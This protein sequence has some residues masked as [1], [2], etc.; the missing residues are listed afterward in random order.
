MTLAQPS[1]ARQIAARVEADTADVR[2][3]RILAVCDRP[4]R[5]GRPTSDGNTLIAV[6]V[7]RR[8]APQCDLTLAWFQETD[9]APDP[10]LV[11]RCRALVPLR[12]SSRVRGLAGLLTGT[13]M[14]ALRRS[15]RR[16]VR[17][18]RE[19]ERDADVVYLHGPATLML[20]GRLE[21]PC[22]VNEIDPLSLVFD[23]QFRR[24]TALGRIDA[25]VRR[26]SAA[27]AERHAR[28][29]AEAY[30]L[31]NPDDARELAAQLRASVTALPNGV[32]P[33]ECRCERSRGARRLC[34]VGALDYGPNI[35]SARFLVQE[36]LPLVRQHFRDIEIVIAG[37]NAVE[38]VRV[39]AHHRGVHILSDV[40]DVMDVYAD[41][42]IAVFPGG[43]GRGTRNSVL[44]AL[45]AGIPSIASAVSAR[46]VQPGEH[47]RIAD[48][49]SEV[50]DAILT[51]VSNPEVYRRAERA[52]GTYGAALPSW[53]W[54]AG[55][56]L[57]L[58]SDVAAG[59]FTNTDFRA[60]GGAS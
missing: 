7:L 60:R 5:S 13:P 19:L 4:P 49:A 12:P 55:R 50:A 53:E 52:A 10:E 33:A 38:A 39:L 43:R 47:C 30:V 36:V 51:L 20:A 15:G 48:S 8:I 31:V 44:E 28:T 3:L 24:A 2:P 41:C 6:E 35:E 54:T 37:R 59:E 45:R 22:V 56:Y 17:T 57:S 40:P 27:A 42:D 1:D 34:F 46:G 26:R 9:L 11:A 18:L 32:T 29:S 58:L 21:R 23:D 14:S 25:A 16:T